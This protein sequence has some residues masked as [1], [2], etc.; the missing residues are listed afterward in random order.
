ME[1]RARGGTHVKHVAHIR[2]AGRVEAQRLVERRRILPSRK[3][4]I[5]C[6]A[7]C[8]GG[9]A[10]G[11]RAAHAA[12]RR[13]LDCRVGR[14][15]GGAHGEHVVHVCD[16]G[17]VEA[18]RLVELPRILPRVER[19]RTLRDEVGTRRREGRE[20]RRHKKRAGEGLATDLG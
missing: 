14:A 13:R 18:Q 3:E 12:C 11:R 8:A 15:R 9:E 20:Q 2:D 6:G 10:G 5:R 1:A 4:G 7:R 17:R 19:R 16:A